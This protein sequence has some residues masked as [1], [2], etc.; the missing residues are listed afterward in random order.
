MFE[1]VQSMNKAEISAFVDVLTQ[2]LPSYIDEAA[3]RARELSQEPE[4]KS[5]DNNKA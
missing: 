5:H 1:Q 4:I 3:K 2:T